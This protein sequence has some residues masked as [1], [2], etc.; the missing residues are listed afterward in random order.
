MGFVSWGLMDR[1][2]KRAAGEKRQI[3]DS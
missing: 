1:F 2:A 3:A